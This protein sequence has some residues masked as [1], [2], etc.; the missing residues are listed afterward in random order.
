VPDEIWY[1]AHLQSEIESRAANSDEEHRTVAAESYV[2]DTSIAHNDR[3]NGA[4]KLRL[5]A[6]A[7]GERVV[8]FGLVPTLRVSKVT[9]D[10]Q[11]AAFIQEDKKD[12]GAFQLCSR[13]QS[14]RA[15]RTRLRSS[16][17]ATR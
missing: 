7:E 15:A 3:F 16:T 13:R 5:R 1:H 14:K 8:P 12:D 6:L 2:I 9:V 17:R 10:G 11:D 4:A